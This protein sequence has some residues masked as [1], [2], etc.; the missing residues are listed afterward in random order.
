MDIQTEPPTPPIPPPIP[1]K[2]Q[3]IQSAISTN[4]NKLSLLIG[5][6]VIVGAI[7][8]G[9][10]I[11]K[12][13]TL[14]NISTNTKQ[15]NTPSPSTFPNIQNISTE[16]W[17]IYTSSESGFMFKYPPEYKPSQIESNY[18]SIIS[19]LNQNRD[20]G[21][22]LQSD[23]LKL[24]ILTEPAKINDS[25]IKC[26]NDHV[27]ERKILKHEKITISG[28]NTSIFGWEGNGSGQLICVNYNGLRFIIYKYPL[29]TSRQ[30]EFDQMISTFKFTYR[31]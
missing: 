14:S 30:S 20:Q 2:N 17:N 21:F 1:P 4:S 27:N 29:I 15:I 9:M 3:D 31:K 10:E 11:G 16:N 23:E 19:P 12:K 8:L 28:I 13:Q 25:P 22:E 6:A 5:I 7:Y 24:E 26:W 18:F